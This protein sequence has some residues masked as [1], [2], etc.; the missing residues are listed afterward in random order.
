MRI[1]GIGAGIVPINIVALISNRQE[2]ND[3]PGAVL[4]QRKI[5]CMLGDVQVGARFDFQ[6]RGSMAGAGRLE[7]HS[8]QNR[9]IICILIQVN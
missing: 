9:G 1:E 3:A 5:R 8:S 4:T 6:W 7:A 2:K